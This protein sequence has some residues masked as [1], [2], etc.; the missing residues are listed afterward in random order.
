ML[1]TRPQVDADRVGLRQIV[2]VRVGVN[3]RTAAVPVLARARLQASLLVAA[4]LTLGFAAV[5]L[6][7]LQ[8]T[9][10]ARKVADVAWSV[11][12]AWSVDPA[13]GSLVG[14]DPSDG[15]L[16]SCRDVSSSEPPCS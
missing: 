7:A 9:G 1:R 4:S 16:S 10:E 8:R 13:E 12:D 14:D 5:H 15:P 3:K 11:G 6:G 2:S